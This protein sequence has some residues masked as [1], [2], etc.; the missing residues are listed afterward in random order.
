[1]FVGFGLKEKPSGFAKNK[2]L[3]THRELARWSFGRPFLGFGFSADS[4][5]GVLEEVAIHVL[6]G[7]GLRL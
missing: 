7:K 2:H 1:M 5:L 6:P 4:R 3:R